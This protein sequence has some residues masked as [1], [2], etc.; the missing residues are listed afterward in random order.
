[1]NAI[2]LR[3][4]LLAPLRIALLNNALTVGIRPNRVHVPLP[5]RVP[6]WDR[7]LQITLHDTSGGFI[8][9]ALETRVWL[10]SQI[11]LRSRTSDR[12]RVVHEG[13]D[14]KAS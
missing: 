14:G 2:I 8:P 10:A 3:I 12:R 1:M 6:A 5:T 11:V 9:C 7:C 13:R 4:D